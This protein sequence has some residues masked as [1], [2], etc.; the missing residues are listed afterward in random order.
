M[1][2]SKKEETQPITAV[3]QNGG[4]SAKFIVSSSIKLF[5]KSEYMYFEFRDFG[6]V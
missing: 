1:K 3:W 2:D 5:Y 6:K 4:F